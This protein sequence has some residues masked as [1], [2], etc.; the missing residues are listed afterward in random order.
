MATEILLTSTPPLLIPKTAIEYH[1]F[2]LWRHNSGEATC[3]AYKAAD[4]YTKIIAVKDAKFRSVSYFGT[5]GTDSSLK[6]F[7]ASGARGYW[8]NGSGQVTH[9]KPMPE[10]INNDSIFNDW[11]AVLVSDK[12]AKE[13]CDVWMTYSVV[14]VVE[15]CRSQTINNKPCDCPNAYQ[16]FCIWACGDKIDE[17]DTTADEY[18]DMRFGYTSTGWLPWGRCQKWNGKT[19]A[20]CFSSTEYSST[21]TYIACWDGNLYYSGYHKNSIGTVVPILEL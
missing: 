1:G 6:S 14:P 21:H 18:S 20:F 3:I 15:Y 10:T 4:T 7:S 2:L 5:H 17:L 8:I 12:S 19:S 9:N 11:S 13:N 16:L